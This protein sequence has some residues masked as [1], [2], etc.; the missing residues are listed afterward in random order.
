MDCEKSKQAFTIIQKEIAL[1]QKVRI[2]PQ[3]YS[4]WPFLQEGRD[5]VI[6][7]PL[8]LSRMHRGD[9]L[10]YRRK[11]QILVLHRLYRKKKNGFFMT[12]DNQRQIEGPVAPRDILGVVTTIQRKQHTFSR[13][14]PLWLLT[15]HLWL[16]LRPVRPLA[17]F[18][19]HKIAKKRKEDHML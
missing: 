17:A 5:S 8:S 1:H 19:Y 7:K 16:L 13:F 3:G 4:M 18:W 9:I 11:D 15:S 12:G 2:Y 6:V 10:L 14:H